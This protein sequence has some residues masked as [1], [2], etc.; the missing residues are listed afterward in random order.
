[1]E[2]YRHGFFM[3][4]CDERVGLA[5]EEGVDIP[6][7]AGPP[8]AGESENGGMGQ[9]EPMLTLGALLAGPFAKVC[10]RHETAAS[11][12]P[13]HQTP[14]R[15]LK[16]P[17]VR[18]RLP[19]ER[20]PPLHGLELLDATVASNDP[21][22]A[23]REEFGRRKP[24]RLRH[25]P[26]DVDAEPLRDLDL[27]GACPVAIAH[28]DSMADGVLACNTPGCSGPSSNVLHLFATRRFGY[29][30]Q[31]SHNVSRGKQGEF[32]RKQRLDELK[33]FLVPGWTLDLS[34]LQ[35]IEVRTVLGYYQR[36][37]D[38]LLRCRRRDCRRRVEVDFR[39]AVQGGLGDRPASYMLEL[40]KCRHWNGC[41][42]E[43]ASATY[44]KGIP[45]VALL[46]EAEVLIAIA[47]A[48]CAARALLPPRE[49]IRRLNAAG[50]GDGS[51]GI[52]ELGQAVRGPCRNC[53]GRRFAAELVWPKRPL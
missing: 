12:I 43:E 38:M 24:L 19:V 33:P 37:Q 39:A 52:L 32:E 13:E 6:H 35:P 22:E 45:L 44:P 31:V 21:A 15:A 29:R 16:V 5:G 51:T 34:R 36:G 3:D 48:V 42:L 11:G 14:E 23:L 40:L 2:D 49:V 53:S 30:R 9:A 18:D 17:H 20:N 4:G 46:G 7:V 50:R 28:Q 8:D 41:Q 10:H 25:E 47:C 27:F 1:M 26:V